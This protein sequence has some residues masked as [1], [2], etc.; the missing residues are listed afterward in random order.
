M[1]VNKELSGH[2]FSWISSL[3]LHRVGHWLT[4]CDFPNKMSNVLIPLVI[5]NHL[6]TMNISSSI[7][8]CTVSMSTGGGQT[9]LHLQGKERKSWEKFGQNSF[10]SGNNH[11]L[12]N[13]VMYSQSSGPR[14]KLIVSKIISENINIDKITRTTKEYVLISVD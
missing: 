8:D 5:S 13:L 3:F 14:G 12:N 7:T 2:A 4:S 10:L 9:I 11:A 1:S 6:P